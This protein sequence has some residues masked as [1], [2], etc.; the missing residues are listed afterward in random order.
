MTFTVDLVHIINAIDLVPK[1]KIHKT[2][3][4]KLIFFL[5][6]LT[7][8]ASGYSC[9]PVSPLSQCPREK[10]RLS[11]CDG[12]SPPYAPASAL[13]EKLFVDKKFFE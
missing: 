2:I 4:I 13:A 5:P 12:V 7:D 1:Q 6:R 8:C 11:P 9:A 3:C 10:P